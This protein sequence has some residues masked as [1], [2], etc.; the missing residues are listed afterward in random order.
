VRISN[1]AVVQTKHR[2]AERRDA[3]DDKP[4]IVPWIT[5][6]SDWHGSI[7]NLTESSNWKLKD[8]APTVRTLLRF[9]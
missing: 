5:F 6:R 8:V 3:H 9:R 4:P 1:R 2:E 7:F